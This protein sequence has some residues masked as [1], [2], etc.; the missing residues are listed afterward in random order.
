M[1]K[2]RM[3][4]NGMKIAMAALVLVSLW[5]SALRAAEVTINDATRA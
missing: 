3:K 4:I 5:G 1:K 2:V